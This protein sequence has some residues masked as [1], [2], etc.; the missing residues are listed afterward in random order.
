MTYVTVTEC[1]GPMPEHSGMGDQL[2]G[3]D[4]L[5]R[6]VGG[7]AF[8]IFLVLVAVQYRRRLR[9]IRRL[10]ES[11]ELLTRQLITALSRLEV[12]ETVRPEM[13]SGQRFPGRSG[14]R[15][16]SPESGPVGRRGS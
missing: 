6:A 14:W 13:E 4:Q 15:V 7:V 9:D 11:N 8:V 10:A 16:D 12:Y 3:F 1:W 5:M 2:A